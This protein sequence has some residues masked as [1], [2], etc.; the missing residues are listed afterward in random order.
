MDAINISF[1]L[2]PVHNNIEGIE[3]AKQEKKILT[4]PIISLFLN[5]ETY[6]DLKIEYKLNGKY[7]WQK[8]NSKLR[9]I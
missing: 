7:W 5:I 1:I 4:E 9:E 2:L 8:Q 3:K 6:N